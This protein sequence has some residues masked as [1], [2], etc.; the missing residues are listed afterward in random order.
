[1]FIPKNLL[2]FAPAFETKEHWRDGRVVDYSSLENY[3]AER[4]RGFES[5]SL[6]KQNVTLLIIRGL[7]FLRCFLHPELHPVLCWLHPIL[8]PRSSNVCQ[9]YH[10]SICIE[11]VSGCFVHPSAVPVVGHSLAGRSFCKASP[12]YEV[13]PMVEDVAKMLKT[14]LFRSYAKRFRSYFV[15]LQPIFR[16]LYGMNAIVN[17]TSQVFVRGQRRFEPTCYV[18]HPFGTPCT[19]GIGL[20]RHQEHSFIFRAS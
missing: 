10:E 20:P 11:V 17:I 2:T 13:S 3:R 6:R 16:I 7:L 1:M 12:R 14:K 15:S 9:N 18:Q 5:L 19:C 8:H 4:H